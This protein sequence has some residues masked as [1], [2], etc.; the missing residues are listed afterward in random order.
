MVKKIAIVLLVL[1]F[2]IFVRQCVWGSETNK[3]IRVSRLKSTNMELSQTNKVGK[4]IR[5][6]VDKVTCENKY[7]IEGLVSRVD[8]IFIITLELIECDNGKLIIQSTKNHKGTFED[9]LEKAVR[10]CAKEV[11]KKAK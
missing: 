4:V 8:D 6:E 9:F 7:A 10:K 1:G 3:N 11:L 2:I 5:Q